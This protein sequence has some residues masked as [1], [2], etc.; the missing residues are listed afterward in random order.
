MDFCV[1]TDSAQPE[2][3]RKTTNSSDLG[4]TPAPQGSKRMRICRQ[5]P[6]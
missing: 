2:A 3:R 6:I 4:G 1:D 5:S